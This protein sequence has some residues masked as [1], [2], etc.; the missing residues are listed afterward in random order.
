MPRSTG[1]IQ[2][3]QTSKVRQASR[4]RPVSPALKRLIDRANWIPPESDADW[5]EFCNFLEP[6]AHAYVGGLIHGRSMVDSMPSMKSWKT[7][8]EPLPERV[9]RFIRLRSK[10]GLEDM[11]PRAYYFV[12]AYGTLKHIAGIRTLV[13]GTGGGFRGMTLP[14][15]FIQY[16]PGAFLNLRVNEKGL[17]EVDLGEIASALA[18]AEADRIRECGL[19]RRIFWAGRSDQ[20]CCI[21]KCSKVLRTRRWRENYPD[22]YKQRRHQKAEQLDPRVRK[23]KRAKEEEE[24]RQIATLKEP[25][26]S[27]R[28]APRLPGYS[29]KTK[30]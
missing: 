5:S 10:Y 3:V 15:P 22:K 9:R 1:H 7:F 17:I 14:I 30:P 4:M 11:I 16:D 28:R 26:R 23:E 2:P 29:A 25:T 27:A 21:P 13:Q 24:R 6:M 19:C 8:F 20:K 18:S 12:A